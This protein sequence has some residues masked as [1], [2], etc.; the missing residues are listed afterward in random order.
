MKVRSFTKVRALGVSALCVAAASVTATAQEVGA[1]KSAKSLKDLVS[2]QTGNV[3]LRNYLYNYDAKTP[4]PY[5]DV[6]TQARAN[7]TVKTFNDVVSTTL[8]VAVSKANDDSAKVISRRP[9]LLT[10]VA[11]FDST[12]Y[13][14]TPYLDLHG[15]IDAAGYRGDLGLAQTLKMPDVET[16]YGAWKMSMLTESFAILGSES[17][18]KEV[19]NVD[20]AAAAQALADLDESQKEKQAESY[21]V[22]VTPNITWDAKGVVD[23]LTI[24]VEAE[25]ENTF[26]PVTDV[27][28]DG[29]TETALQPVREMYSSLVIGYKV[30][31]SLSLTNVTAVGH[32]GF[33][34]KSGRTDGEQLQNLAVLSYTMY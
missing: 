23:G 3:Q 5:G 14:A 18:V 27:K 2:S 25:Y 29:S 10:E 13:S 6:V 11:A 7:L 9:R 21:V 34:E 30:N 8:T 26:T 22:R 24:G 12:Y 28:A 31:D 20:N 19:R 15:K 32:T 1:T 4:N 17:A 33:W 16:S